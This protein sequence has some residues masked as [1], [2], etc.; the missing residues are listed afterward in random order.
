MSLLICTSSGCIVTVI[1]E[2]W[3][4]TITPSTTDHHLN[5]ISISH[6]LQIQWINYIP[7]VPCTSK[8]A[9]TIILGVGKSIIYIIIIISH[10]IYLN[11]LIMSAIMHF[12][13]RINQHN[14]IGTEKNATECIGW[15]FQIFSLLS[16]SYEQY[17]RHTPLAGDP[18][19]S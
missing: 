10:K 6:K 15:P 13:T 4:H 11:S 2:V 12:Y 19:K 17:E 18:R 3:E 8:C 9:G 16:M 14:H 1:T 5:F 7:R